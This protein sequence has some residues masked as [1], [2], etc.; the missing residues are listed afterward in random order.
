MVR[1]P[2]SPTAF[3]AKEHDEHMPE[4]LKHIVLGNLHDYLK[5]ATQDTE[6]LAQITRTAYNLCV[7]T[8]AFWEHAYDADKT[9]ALKA[10]SPDAKIVSEIANTYKHFKPF[11]PKTVRRIGF[12]RIKH[13]AVGRT[14]DTGRSQYRV[15][16][17]GGHHSLRD[18]PI[19]TENG[20]LTLNELLGRV[21]PEVVRFSLSRGWISKEA[22][23][24]I[25]GD[26]DVLEA[27]G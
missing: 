5:A 9:A 1:L 23:E 13:I 26:L 6:D 11:T 27:M 4:F 12:T 10:M 19:E 16:Q 17:P 15:T 21:I 25:L 7:A 22:A 2:K 3:W 14:P 20:R 24:E 8:S 18:I